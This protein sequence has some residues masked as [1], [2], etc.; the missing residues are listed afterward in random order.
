MP[1]MNVKP[2][3]MEFVKKISKA[4]E[5][6]QEEAL[7]V[8]VRAGIHRMNATINYAKKQKK[9]SKPRKPR[10][11]KPKAEKKAPKKKASKKSEASLL[12]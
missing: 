12:D 3:H 7:D 1:S 5:I 8:V 4:R 11:S 6:T 2:E 9:E 10:A